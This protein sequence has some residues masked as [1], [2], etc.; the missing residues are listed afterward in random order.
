MQQQ[1]LSPAAPQIPRNAAAQ[2][3]RCTIC[4]SPFYL[5]LLAASPTAALTGASFCLAFEARLKSVP[6]TTKN[7]VSDYSVTHFQCQPGPPVCRDAPGPC[8]PLPPCLSPG[9][10]A[11]LL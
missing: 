11:P 4:S 6:A 2:G 9:H 8:S 3:P 1:Q 7:L 10:G 5:L